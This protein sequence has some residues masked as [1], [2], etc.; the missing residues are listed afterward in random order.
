MSLVQKRAH[1]VFVERV[2]EGE[3]AD[4]MR[5]V[6]RIRIEGWKLLGAALLVCLL[7]STGFADFYDFYIFSDNGRWGENGDKYG[8]PLLDLS[9]EVYDGAETAHFKFTNNS[10]PSLEVSITDIYFADGSLLGISSI[11]N[12]DGYT[13]FDKPANPAELPD[14]TLLDPD[15]I[16]TDYENQSFSADSNAPTFHNGVLTNEWVIINFALIEGGTIEQVISELNNGDLRIGLHI[17]G[18][19][20]GSSES[21]VNVPEPATIILLGLG[22]L[23]VLR[24][25]RG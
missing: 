18:F 17:Q 15:F 14:N 10:D 25:R 1:F 7:C 24:K 8:D 3:F 6:A 12:Q 9:V 20:D 16:T 2:Y 13:L 21:A 11:E 23:A 22:G 19:T 4:I 5:D